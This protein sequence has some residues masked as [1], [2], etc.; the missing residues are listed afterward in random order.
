MFSLANRE[1]QPLYQ[2]ARV[3]EYPDLVISLRLLYDLIR[4]E[5]GENLLLCSKKFS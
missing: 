3:V 4:R 2:K 1:E 5:T